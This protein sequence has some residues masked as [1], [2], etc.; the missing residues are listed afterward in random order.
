MTNCPLCGRDAVPLFTKG[1]AP[2]FR[3]PACDFR[4]ARP[5][6][7]PNFENRL[8]DFEAA[9]LH[10]LRPEPVDEVNFVALCRWMERFGG[11][12]GPLLDVGCGSGK[13]VRFLRGCG[14]EA[15]GLEPC[16][17]LY[18]H[19]LSGEPWFVPGTAA[20][21]RVL[22]ERFEVVT[23][24]DVMEHVDD[25]AAVLGQLANRLA[26]GGRLYVSTPDVGSL[27]ARLLGR[28][29]HFYGR[30]HLSY[31]NPR[32]LTALAARCGL[33]RTH[34]SWR[35]RHRSLGYAARY[36]FEFV[37]GRAAPAWLARLDRVTL[38]INLFDTMYLC[39]RKPAVVGVRSRAAA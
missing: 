19:F 17:A 37:A 2:F 31:F 8:E 30:Y 38:P 27:A 23:A 7:N 34:C 18:D 13:L 28:R 15:Y 22:R 35:G 5:P 9:Y 39:F 24:F 11:L 29:W 26:P 21:A 10:Y 6:S 33:A 4:F 32:T 12:G 20:D 3:C 1:G 36:L 25:P 16:R 14:V